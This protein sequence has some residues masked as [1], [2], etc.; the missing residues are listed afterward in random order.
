MRRYVPHRNWTVTCDIDQVFNE[1]S[2][3]ILAGVRDG[4]LTIG[5]PVRTDMSSIYSPSLYVASALNTS[6]RCAGR[7]PGPQG[8]IVCMLACSLFNPCQSTIRT[9]G[10]RNPTMLSSCAMRNRIYL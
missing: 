8:R 10:V 6:G 3:R 4:S 1:L 9:R 5:G 2:K 7:L